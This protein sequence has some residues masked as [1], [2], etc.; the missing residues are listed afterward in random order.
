V[1]NINMLMI[2]ERHHVWAVVV[3]AAADDDDEAVFMI[4]IDLTIAKTR[5]SYRHNQSSLFLCPV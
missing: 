2:S 1:F 4:M 3:V 5:H